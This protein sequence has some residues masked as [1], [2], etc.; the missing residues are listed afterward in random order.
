MARL[1]DLGVFHSNEELQMAVREL[2]QMQ[3]RDLYRDGYLKLMPTQDKCII[4]LRDYVR[5]DT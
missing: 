2:W 4:V 1:F 3:E 5:K